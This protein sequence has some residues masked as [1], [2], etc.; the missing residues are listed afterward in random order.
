MTAEQFR[1]WLDEMQSSGRARSDAE[2]GR[3]LGLTPN[4]VLKRKAQGAGLEAALACQAVLHGMKPY[5]D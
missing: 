2:C 4:G 3:L 5:G 1:A